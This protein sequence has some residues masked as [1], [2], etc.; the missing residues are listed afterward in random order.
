M[1]PRLLQSQTNVAHT[2]PIRTMAI[3]PRSGRVFATGGD[4][5]MLFL[6]S[7]T[8]PDPLLS[9]G[10]FQSPVSCST[11]SLDEN[12]IAFGTDNGF[13]SIIDLDQGHTLNAWMIYKQTKITCISIHPQILDCIVVGDEEGDVYLFGGEPRNPIQQYKAHEGQVYSVKIC[14]QGNFLATSG[15]D[16]LIRIYDISKGV[17]HGTINP[18]KKFDSPL[19]CLDFH[20]TEQILAACAEDRNV[21]IYD[22]NRV[23][24]M[25]NGF[26]I[27]KKSPL[28][29]TFSP[30]GEVVASCSPSSLS[31]FKTADAYQEDHLKLS[32]K[33]IQDLKVFD[34]G[35]AI[36][37]SDDCQGNV[38]IAKTEDFVFNKRK[39]KKKQ[40][41]SPSPDLFS[42]AQIQPQFPPKKK[43][44]IEPLPSLRPQQ[45]V[46]P[47]P[48]SNEPLFRAF[49]EDRNEFMT[50]I[51][52][53][54][55]KYRKISDSIR[56]KGLKETLNMVSTTRDAIP[57]MVSS[58]LQRTEA[59]SPSTASAIIEVVYVGVQIDE[60]LALRLL[61]VVL[62]N[63][64]PVFRS[65]LDNPRSQ[66]FK[67]AES[68]KASCKTL[69]PLFK[70]L[71]ENRTPGSS[72]MKRLISEYKTFFM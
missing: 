30:D 64:S 4:D 26:L 19:F 2:Q 36:G 40:K 57:E 72:M 28:K 29:I 13:L 3:G 67:D 35:I 11:F 12:H 38:I 65:A 60:D 16:H 59:I 21:K 6:W 5:C 41:R 22:I 54:T 61:R 46:T 55:A 58:L 18:T 24:E 49:R 62:Q 25:R 68:F 69:I 10:P 43:V 48:A 63:L 15:E 20:P 9:F 70:K 17:V 42:P 8:E 37:V 34:K 52:Q 50:V 56:D 51:S 14:P 33:N 53:R 27:G 1:I 66:Y 7:I 44:I 32:L 47:Q 23:I 71:A 31:V 45:T 39:K